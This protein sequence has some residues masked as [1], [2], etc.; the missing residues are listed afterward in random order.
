MAT[1]ALCL[2]ALFAAVTINVCNGACSNVNIVS[3]SQW[4]A[5][6]ATSH[7]AMTVPVHEFF[8]HHTETGACHDH[9]SCSA[10]VRSIQ[11]YHMTHNGWSDIGYSFL[12]GGDGNVY[13]GRGWSY[14]GAHT[15]NYN[16]KAFAASMIGSF[17]TSLP[18]AQALAAVKHLI[19]C[20]IQ[21]G[22]IASDY[23][24]YGHRDGGQTDCPGNALYAEIQKW[25]HYSH[26][27]P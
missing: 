5:K 13:E 25:P 24:L 9:A 27:H 4:G 14:V 23:R 19:D 1:K 22:K 6:A 11:D 15:Q 21:Q 3:R 8:I 18:T 12:V 26:T 10:V 16:S 2:L 7:S 20:G 17:M